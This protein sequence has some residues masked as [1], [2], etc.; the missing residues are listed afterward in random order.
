[1]VITVMNKCISV[2]WMHMFLSLI[3]AYPDHTDTVHICITNE[4]VAKQMQQQI[5]K[6]YIN[7]HHH[8]NQVHK[9]E[10]YHIL[11]GYFLCVVGCC[12]V[13]FA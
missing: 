13:T 12:G 10:R 6:T 5:Q 1:M 4:F 9:M 2:A 8:K 11:E 3:I 7:Y